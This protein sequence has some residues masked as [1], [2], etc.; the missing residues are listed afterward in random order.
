[1]K[2]ILIDV[3]GIGGAYVCIDYMKFIGGIDVT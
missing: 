3:S 1:M 2:A